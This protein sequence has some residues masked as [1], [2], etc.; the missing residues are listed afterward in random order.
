MMLSVLPIT[1]CRHVEPPQFFPEEELLPIGHINQLY[2]VQ[3]IVKGDYAISFIEDLPDYTV[4]TNKLS[5]PNLHIDIK[6]TVI[7]AKLLDSSHLY[8]LVIFLFIFFR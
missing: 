7:L 3:I 1:G 5:D 6:E 2:Q 8:G 4:L